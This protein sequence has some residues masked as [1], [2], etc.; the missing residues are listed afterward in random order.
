MC[1]SMVYSAMQWISGE[2]SPTCL[3]T[4]KVLTSSWGVVT[5]GILLTQPFANA[6]CQALE[7]VTTE[8]EIWKLKSV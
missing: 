2:Y 4:G 7:K 3:P 1:M 5:S 6:W 8:N